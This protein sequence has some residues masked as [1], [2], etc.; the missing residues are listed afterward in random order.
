MEGND[1]LDGGLGVDTLIGGEGSDTYNVDTITDI[2]I[3]NANEGNADT[4]QTSVSFNMNSIDNVE[5]LYGI[6]HDAINLTGNSLN[7][8]IL[9]NSNNNEINGGEGHDRIDGKFGND[10]LTG[11]NGVEWFMFTTTLDEVNNVDNILDFTSGIDQIRLDNYIFSS[12]VSTGDISN[13]HFFQGISAASAEHFIIY[14]NTTGALYYDQD[15][16][17]GNLMVQFANLEANTALEYSDFF[18]I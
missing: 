8:T 4:I 18:I 15:G 5:R 9:G 17:G 6:G 2:I 16:D 12:F 13:N 1:F 14:D 10:T 7:N 11:G 3:E